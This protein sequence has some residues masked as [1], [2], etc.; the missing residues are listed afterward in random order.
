MT[1][2]RGWSRILCVS[3]WKFH[4][5]VI[6]SEQTMR[7]AALTLAFYIVGNETIWDDPRKEQLTVTSDVPFAC[8]ICTSAMIRVIIEEGWGSS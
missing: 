5:R 4:E 7:R 8:P 3:N 1:V 6:G 2:Q